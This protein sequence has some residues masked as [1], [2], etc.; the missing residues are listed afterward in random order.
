MKE[1]SMPIRVLIVDDE[2]LAREKMCELME[3]V[4]YIVAGVATDGEEAL[5]LTESLRPDVVLMDINMPGISG[6][7]AARL[8]QDRC[9]TPVVIMTA[10]QSP[11]LL[12]DAADAGIGAYLFKPPDIRQIERTV[13]IAMARFQDLMALRRSNAELRAEIAAR[14]KAEE[15]RNQLAHLNFALKSGLKNQQRFGDLIGK[16]REMHLVYKRILH[17]AE[18]D[19]QILISGE[20]GTGKELAARMV[21]QLSARR[22]APFVPVNCGAIPEALFESEAFGYRKGAFTDART[23]RAGFF[24]AAHQGTLFLDEIGELGL[25][26]QVKL[27]RAIEG[28]GYTPV[29]AQM[30]KMSDVR[31]IAA[32]NRNLQQQVR[33]GR[34]RQDFFYR[35]HVLTMSMPPLRKRK[36]DI[37][38]LIEHFLRQL[39]TD[40]SVIPEEVMSRLCAYDWPGNVRE[41]QNVLRRYLVIHRLEFVDSLNPVAEAAEILP[42]DDQEYDNGDYYAVMQ[43]FEKCYL[44][45]ML[46]RHQW[47]KTLTAERLGIPLR[48]F[49]RRL[50]NLGLE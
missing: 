3:I 28:H 47:N 20:S 16:S 42:T 13:P 8:I 33:E 37:P 10:Y 30:P 43:A 40:L 44:L 17:A 27:L 34:M 32:T 46:A 14:Q 45:K 49:H 35:V 1:A 22:N 6:I 26:Q 15:E 38:L 7:E 39:G 25:M 41:L 31:I 19:E 2:T 9:P 12:Q 23:D 18:S 5:A 50:K 36:E 48:T 21:H 24:E 29:G 4:E 11:E